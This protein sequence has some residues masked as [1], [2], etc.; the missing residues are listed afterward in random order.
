MSICEIK[1]VRDVR[2]PLK[3]VLT[4]CYSDLDLCMDLVFVLVL[5]LSGQCLVEASNKMAGM[6]LPSSWVKLGLN[7]FLHLKFF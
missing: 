2:V 7:I 3:L 4:C 1:T 6:L 5:V